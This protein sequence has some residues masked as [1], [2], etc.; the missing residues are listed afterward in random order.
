MGVRESGSRGV[1]EATM[2]WWLAISLTMGILW[3]QDTKPKTPPPPK[4]Q[5]EQEPPEEDES[6]KPRE[7]GFN[8]LK[9]LQ[10]VAIGNQYFKKHNY[11]AALSRYQEATKWNPNLAEAYLRLGEAA[12]KMKDKA[13]AKQAYQKYIELAPDSKEAEQLKKTWGGK[14]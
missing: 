6:L 9:A 14:S 7:Y 13:T 11:R 2:R 12:E 1:R 4:E 5:Q 3:A 8:P 10:D